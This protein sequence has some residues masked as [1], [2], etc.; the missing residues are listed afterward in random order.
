MEIEGKYLLRRLPDLS[1][2][3]FVRIEQHYVCLS[4][5]EEVRLRK[6]G[7]KFFITV[8]GNGTLERDEWESEISQSVYETL[9]SAARGRSVLKDRYMIALPDG[10]M[11]ELDI[12]RGKL[13]G[14]DHLTVEVEFRGKEEADVFKKPWW[15]G[16]DI[17]NDARYKNR[18]LA[19]RGWPY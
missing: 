15:F 5:E 7:D 17:T 14:P 2:A 6:K 11:A 12:Y 16:E 3:E 10:N 18:N 9:L 1:G 19:T 13:E 4:E 8:K